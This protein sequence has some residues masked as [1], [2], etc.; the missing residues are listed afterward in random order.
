MRA[1]VVACP[2]EELLYFPVALSTVTPSEILVLSA[3]STPPGEPTCDYG[4]GF[5][6]L[7]A[8]S[9]YRSEILGHLDDEDGR[10]LPEPLSALLRTALQ[11]YAVDDVYTYAIQGDK[12]KRYRADVAMAVWLATNGNR[13]HF[14]AKHTTRITGLLQ[15]QPERV[16]HVF[17]SLLRYYLVEASTAE[18]SIQHTETYTSHSFEEARVAYYEISHGLEG[19][20]RLTAEGDSDPWGY[21]SS[22]YAEGRA[23]DTLRLVQL[24]LRTSQTG[25]VWEI[26]PASGHVTERLLSLP[27]VSHVD[28]I[29][30]FN[31]FRQC[32]IRHVG[33]SD[34]L[35]VRREDMREVRVWDC[36]VAI[37]VDCLDSYL[38]DQDQFE[39]VSSALSSGV[40]VIVGGEAS[41][42]SS[43]VERLVEKSDI[44]TRGKVTRPGAFEPMRFGFPV[45]CPRPAWAAYLLSRLD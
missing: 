36:D 18:T 33:Q 15:M 17:D 42:A 21:R 14:L 39:V 3:H 5:Y 34:K 12:G 22:A 38:T 44:I 13:C 11:K 9:G 8:D 43:F 20:R 16:V 25:V 23:T 45:H 2:T 37:L 6:K 7:S 40:Q 35:T 4:E 10:L 30:R 31:E 28:A 26:G 24:A 27:Q 41:W 29:E 1:I 32:L 19:A